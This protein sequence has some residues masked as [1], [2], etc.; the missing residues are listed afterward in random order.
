MFDVTLDIFLTLL[1][2]C[3]IF[4][5]LI[6]ALTIVQWAKTPNAPS[7]DSNRINNIMSW[8]IGLTRPEVMGAAHK[9]FR[10]DVL[11]NVK[12]IDESDSK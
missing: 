12:D 8:W 3:G 5:T 10:Q 7:D 11:K 1:T 6:G 4:C 9:A 2:V